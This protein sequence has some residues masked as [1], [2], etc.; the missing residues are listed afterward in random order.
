[1]ANKADLK[2]LQDKLDK[3]EAEG[4]AKD[5]LILSQQTDLEQAKPSTDAQHN[6]ASIRAGQDAG[7]IPLAEE[8]ERTMLSTGPASES[9]QERGF[10]LIDKPY[11]AEKMQELAFMEEFLTVRVHDTTDGNQVMVPP[12]WNGGTV[13]YFIRGKEQTV[14]RKYVER[15][16][17]AKITTFTQR[18]ERDANDDEVYVQVPHTALIYPFEVIEDANPRGRDWLRA[19][20]QDHS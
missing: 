1:M 15:L 10:D 20:V 14:K 5:A 7:A 13:Q 17:R 11:S 8:R 16:A 19:I 3:L 6:P 2:K 12:V 9:L 4:A 18:K